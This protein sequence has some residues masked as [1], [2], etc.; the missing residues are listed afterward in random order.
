MSLVLRFVDSDL[1]IREDFVKFIHCKEGLTGFDLANLI[2]N[3]ITDLGIDIQN[4]RGQGYDGAGAVSGHTKGLSARILGINRK[5]LYVHCHS[6]R[7]NLCVSNSCKVQPVRNM[8]DHVKDVSY[9]YNLS[10]NRQQCLELHVGE[11][12]PGIKRK[13]LKDVCRTRWMEMISGLDVFE[14]LFVAIVFSLSAMDINVDRKYNAATS[15]KAHSFLKLLTSFDFIVSLVITRSVFDLTLPVIELLQGKSIDILDGFRLVQSLKDLVCAIRNNIDQY[16]AKWYSEALHLATSVNTEENSPRSCPLQR[17]RANPPAESVSD[18]FKKSLT[19][20]L[21]DHLNSDLI[22]RFDLDSCR[23]YKG[24]SVIPVNLLSFLNHPTEKSWKEDF[25]SFVEFYL[26]DF[27]NSMALDGEMELWE[28]YW[29]TYKGCLPDNV[30]STLKAI[31]FPGFENIKVALRIIGTIPVTSC[32][33]ERSFSALRR[34]K[35]YNRSTMVEERFNG[36]ALMHVHCEIKPNIN[37]V[38][39]RFASMGKHRLEFSL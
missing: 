31:N 34:L 1:N 9:F 13:K 4:C 33:C 12:C 3:A 8:M 18:Y 29:E 6:H 32:E 11:H 17:N 35:N 27:P 23:I 22:Q 26:D 28:K 21:V 19:I 36:L 16:H 15:S 7:L 37:A 24:L 30:S 39:N 14:E 20:P 2:S 25:K 5:A 10:Q 38:I